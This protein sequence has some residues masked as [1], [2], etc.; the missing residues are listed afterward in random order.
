MEG[1]RKITWKRDGYCTWEDRSGAYVVRLRSSAAGNSYAM[2]HKERGFCY[3][4]SSLE[5]C[6]RF[7][8]KENH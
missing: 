3:E 6:A 7:A 8:E 2:F 4:G 1:D 5:D